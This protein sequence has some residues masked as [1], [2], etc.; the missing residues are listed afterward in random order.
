MRFLY[1]VGQLCPN[2]H[3]RYFQI[4]HNSA[5][6]IVAVKNYFLTLKR[7]V[8]IKDP[9]SSDS[10]GTACPVVNYH[11]VG[12]RTN[13]LKVESLR[14]KAVVQLS[15]KQLT[16]G[17]PQPALHKADA[18]GFAMTVGGEAVILNC[19]NS[20]KSSIP[21]S[22]KHSLTENSAL[23]YAVV[24]HK[25][26]HWLCSRKRSGGF[27]WLLFSATGK[28]LLAFPPAMRRGDYSLQNNYQN[29]ENRKPSQQQLTR[30]PFDSAQGDAIGGMGV[31]LKKLQYNRK[32]KHQLLRPSI[33]MSL[34]MMVVVVVIGGKR[35]KAQT[36]PLQIGDTIPEAVWNMPLSVL[37]QADGKTTLR[38]KDNRAKTLLLVFCNTGCKITRHQLLGIDSLQ[39]VFAEK[40]QVVCIAQE[41]KTV[42]LNFLQQDSLMG[43]FKLPLV[44]SHPLLSAY[45]P[46]QINPHVIWIKGGKL[47]GRSAAEYV[48]AKNL[49]TLLNEDRLAVPLKIDR[50]DFKLGKNSVLDEE[51]SSTFYSVLR[52]YLA[53]VTP[54]FKVWIDSTQ[55]SIHTQIINYPAYRI[56]LMALNKFLGMPANQMLWEVA[57][58]ADFQYQEDTGFADS[59]NRKHSY[60][61]ESVLPLA[62]PVAARLDKICK[63]LDLALGLHGRLALRDTL[64]WRLVKTGTLPV[65]KGGKAINTLHNS[66]TAEKTLR[67][68]GLKT[69][70]YEMNKYEENP[71]V[72]DGTGFKGKVD[73]DL[74]IPSFTD[75]YALQA[76]LASH[77]LKLEQV[78][79]PVT[80]FILTENKLKPTK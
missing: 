21:K 80:F 36:K 66:K 8:N 76:E 40:L 4:Y 37:N 69:L 13:R 77:H 43:N 53:G 41:E 30:R 70:V 55:E 78:R 72:I 64:V 5:L 7:I 32:H 68:A 31:P 29:E 11:G 71:P 3:K 56:Y 1:P 65:S 48:T 19:S 74:Y 12:Y 58:R 26:K 33:V 49:R 59:W 61:Y 2:F 60:C 24:M 22:N 6:I 39:Q 46:H 28:K 62:T 35:T 17:L 54:S 9:L 38:L 67:N 18:L 75:F 20:V 42:A 73:M 34:L 10:G 25:L 63:D 15:K 14:L 45:F 44:K 51:R 50:D 23:F 52:P 57:N 16:W 79:L 27:F 47:K